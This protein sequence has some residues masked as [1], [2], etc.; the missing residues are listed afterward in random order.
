LRR[1]SH[2]DVYVGFR[3]L[4][5]QD[6]RLDLLS[7]ALV[8]DTRLNS[9]KYPGVN[10]PLFDLLK[11]RL[12]VG[13]GDVLVVDGGDLPGIPPSPIEEY[14]SC[15]GEEGRLETLVFK[16]DDRLFSRIPKAVEEWTD[17]SSNARIV[18][19]RLDNST[20]DL[21]SLTD[22]FFPSVSFFLGDLD[23]EDLEISELLRPWAFEDFLFGSY[24]R[25]LELVGDGPLVLRSEE[26]GGEAPP[27][28]R[29]L[30]VLLVFMLDIA[31][32]DV[33]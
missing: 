8:E 10:L 22:N 4:F 15:I 3:A 6:L 1:S 33:L 20:W 25:I 11:L 7:V 31:D 24:S 26:E 30:L 27:D 23:C 16:T 2:F 19:S 17:E 13:M 9:D 21:S 12:G 28:E 32:E 18:S 14:F 5:I 29:P